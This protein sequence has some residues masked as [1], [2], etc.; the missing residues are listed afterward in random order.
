M[1]LILNIILVLSSGF[2]FLFLLFICLF[3]IF[4]VFYF[5]RFLKP[6]SATTG[7]FFRG[8][9]LRAV[10]DTD[11]TRSEVFT[12]L[13]DQPGAAHVASSILLVGLGVSVLLVAS[14]A[15]V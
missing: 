14:D 11:Q 15:D 3:H 13:G 10:A 12:A 1:R 4:S 6:R 5:I 8:R 2:D 9:V 7:W